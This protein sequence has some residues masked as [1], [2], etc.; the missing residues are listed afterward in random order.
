MHEFLSALCGGLCWARIDFSFHHRSIVYFRLPYLRVTKNERRF[1]RDY[2]CMRVAI[3]RAE[4]R[5]INI[6]RT[7]I[8]KFRVLIYA[9]H[10][11]MFSFLRL[12]G[13]WT[14][15]AVQAIKVRSHRSGGISVPRGSCSAEFCRPSFPKGGGRVGPDAATLIALETPN[16]A[17]VILGPLS[18]AEDPLAPGSHVAGR[19]I[20]GALFK[21]LL[22]DALGRE[23]GS[24]PPLQALTHVVVLAVG[25][26]AAVP[27]ARERTTTS[28]PDAREEGTAKGR[29]GSRKAWEAEGGPPVGMR[30]TGRNH[31]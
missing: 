30:R 18:A 23:D 28:Q 2:S 22:G 13:R 3:T 6:L 19:K 31:S 1:V 21:I 20:R 29:A 16:L 11:P 27:H 5:Y 7:S 25:P 9:A 12:L 15:G 4:V 24:L 10:M 8:A 26:P 17:V 14:V